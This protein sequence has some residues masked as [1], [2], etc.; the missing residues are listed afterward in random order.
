MK[1]SLI[2]FSIFV[3]IFLVALLGFGA[4]MNRGQNNLTMEMA[5]A[6]LP[7]VGF[8]QGDVEI[9]QLHGYT[10]EMDTAFQRDTIL[11]LGASREADFYIDTY[12][13]NINS[14]TMEVRSIDGQRLI[15]ETP[16]TEL[17][18]KRTRITGQLQLKD[19]LEADQEYQLVLLLETEEG[20]VIRYYTRCIWS[21]QLYVQEKVDFV[22]DFHERLFDAE[23]A[24]TLTRY[25]ET[26][27]KLEDNS[28]FHKVNIHSSLKQLT[29]GDLY[30]TRE[31]EPAI[32]ITEMANQTAS[33]MMKFLVSGPAQKG[34]TYYYVEEYYRIRYT[35]TRMYLLDYQRTMTQIPDVQNMYANDKILLGIT[36][37]QVKMAESEDGNV[38]VF[39]VAGKLMSYNA[40]ANKLAVLFSF[41]DEENMDARTLW[42]QHD[43]KILD[44]S[45]GG[46]VQFAVYGYMNRGRNEGRVGIQ[47]YHYDC[48]LNTIEE[49]AYIPYQKNF[50]VLQAEM[51]KLLYLNRDQR[52]YLTLENQVYCINLSE[53]TIH[54]VAHI[55]QDN[56]LFVSENHE[57]MVWLEEDEHKHTQKLN[58]R[59]MTN[60]VQRSI[61]VGMEESIRPLGFMGEDIIYG[62]AYKEDIVEESTGQLFVPMY[63]VCISNTR[64]ELLKE[65]SRDGIYITGCTV[66]NNQITLERCE[67][68]QTGEYRS[69][70][71]DNIMNN[72]KQETR[73]NTISVAVIDVYEEYVQIKT[74]K[75]I[76]SKNIKIQTPKELVFEGGRELEWELRDSGR[77]YVY[78]QGRVQQIFCGPAGAINLAYDVAGVVVNQS[79]DT[80]WYRGNRVARNQIMAIK[81]AKVTEE[82]NAL[83]VC[84]DTIFAYEGKV[85]NSEYLLAEGDSV[86]DIMQEQ[87]EDCR[88]LNL[89]GCTLDALLYYVN[90]DIPVLAMVE[91]GDAVLVTGF[92]EYNVVIMDPRNGTLAKKGMNDSTQW[93]A[94]NGNSFITY[95]RE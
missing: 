65:Y 77:Y 24:K 33:F 19:L 39:E 20:D 88:I 71:P 76:D 68:T 12:G 74:R 17:T 2:K 41:Y 51:E 79:G 81:E 84:L 92:N 54:E 21:Q 45:E 48:A 80:I 94:E 70:E 9:N 25:L 56:G 85:R 18:A 43:I 36:D 87:L 10:Q 30:V 22:V 86:V 15:E 29:Y 1:K 91:N 55:H 58:V 63:K 31:W 64:G 53:R 6:S 67:R 14:V 37:S 5:Q 46:N 50:A 11:V 78:N 60:D 93:F 59:N 72:E 49:I 23:K 95:S 61:E 28:S 73:K 66:D 4:I 3:L 82:K 34:R 38:L 89:T 26:N 7:V 62:V 90:Q 8:F 44:V 69:I 52:M 16:L 40:T 83:A 32:Q 42:K 47:I 75:T 13:R 35:S 57:T 27:S